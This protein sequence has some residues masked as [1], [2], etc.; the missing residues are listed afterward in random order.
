MSDI[1]RV[2]ILDEDSDE[3]RE[4]DASLPRIK[5]PDGA[6]DE[7]GELMNMVIR[8]DGALLRAGSLPLETISAAVVPA[9]RA[10]GIRNVEVAEREHA[11]TTWK[12]A[13][14][15][16]WVMQERAKGRPESE[17]TWGNCVRE[18]GVLRGGE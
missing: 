2:E 13:H 6:P 5:P 3:Y 10:T 9:I 16:A 11:Q 17:L 12:V 14:M 18:T 4:A 1:D 7:I 8:W 15:K